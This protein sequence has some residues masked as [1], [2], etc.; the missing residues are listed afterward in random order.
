ML[1]VVQ[2]QASIG[3]NRLHFGKKYS[4]EWFWTQFNEQM[5]FILLVTGELLSIYT[6][7]GGGAERQ[8]DR[9][10]D[11]QPDRDTKTQKTLF[12]RVIDKHVFFLI[13][14]LHPALAQTKDYSRSNY[15]CAH[16]LSCD[17]PVHTCNK[18]SLDV[19][20]YMR[21]AGIVAHTWGFERERDR[22]TDRQR[23]RGREQGNK[24]TKR[25][26]QEQ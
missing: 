11:S 12:T 14:F 17:T 2:K 6:W 1:N 20:H 3:F 25:N 7:G 24:K 26:N 4:N 9:Q 8:T 10:I 22:Q 16:F 18:W 23:D 5:R 13:C 21:Q 19:K 15:T